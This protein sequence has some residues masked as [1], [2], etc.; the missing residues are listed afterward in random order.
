MVGGDVDV[1]VVVCLLVGWLLALLTCFF[2]GLFHCLQK[3]CA[4]YCADSAKQ[5]STA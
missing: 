2:S 4:M 3:H 1:V 5:A